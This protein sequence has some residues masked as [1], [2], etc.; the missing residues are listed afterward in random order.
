MKITLEKVTVRELFENYSNKDEEGV[1]GY[2][3]KLDIR[4]KYQREFIYDNKEKIEVI[5]TIKKGFPLN[6]MYWVKNNN[7]SYE[8][9]DGQQRTLSICTYLDN[10]FNVNNAYFHN[11]TNDQKKE[12]LD[13]ELQI[14]ICEGTESEK[15]EW[16]K[17]INI[18]GKE[19][20]NQELRNAVYTGDWLTDAKRYFSKRSSGGVDLAKNYL[21]G[22]PNRQVF[23]EKI[24]KWKNH[25]EG[26]ESIEEFMAKHQHDKDADALW[27][28]FQEVT[29]WIQRVFITHRKEMKGLDWGIFFNLYKDNTYNSNEIEQK[30]K[31]LMMDDEIK[32]KKGIYEYLLTK[33]EKS[34][35]LRAFTESQR[36][37][38]YEKQDG[39]CKIC[40]DKFNLSEMHGDHIKPWSK[41]G[42]TTLENGQMLCSQCN[43]TKGNKY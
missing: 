10:D 40:K 19:L 35:N 43:Q 30:T 29:S 17:I 8:L 18:A 16:F 41:G 9:L 3:G 32:N 33:N 36:R 11:L 25:E 20:T 38:M 27:Q 21:V 14:Y 7:D 15:L 23:L 37:S 2:N 5:N 39:Y 34:L 22:D 13:Y 4:P 28:Y 6:T 24:L 26:G 12:I 1:V 42:K 31:E